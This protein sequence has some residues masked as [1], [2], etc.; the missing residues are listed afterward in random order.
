VAPSETAIASATSRGGIVSR[1]ELFER[2]AGAARVTEVSAPAGSGKTFLLRSWVRAARLTDDTAWVAVPRGGLDAPGFWVTVLDALRGTVVGSPLVRELTGAP[3]LDGWS[4]VERL[5]DDLQSLVQP[6]WVVIDDLHELR[7]DAALRQL[8]LLLMRAPEELRFVLATRHN[9]G[10]GLHRLR[11]ERGLTELRAS[12]LRFT[13]QEARAL[14]EEAGVKLSDRAVELLEARTEGWAAGLR[15]AALSLAGNSDPERFAAEFSGSERTVAQ[16]LL[17]EVLERQPEDV[18]RLLLR[19]SIL[20]RVNGELAELLT[21]APGGAALLHALE[22]ANAF[23]SSI[24]AS[25]SW[26]RYHQMF[27]DLLA[28]ELRRTAADEIPSLHRAAAEWFEKHGYH[29]EAVRHAQ[30]AKDWELAVRVLSDHWFDLVLSGQAPTAHDLVA[31]FRA[32]AAVGNPEL[33]A[34]RAAVALSRGSFEQAERQLAAARADVA[35]VPEARRGHFQ[36]M[37]GIHRL[38]IAR[39]RADLPAVA[40]EADR[41]L[42]PMQCADLEHPDISDRRHALALISLGIAEVWTAGLDDAERHLDEGIAQARRI[43]Q[44]YLEFTGLAHLAIVLSF[45]TFSL[46]AERSTEAIEMAQRHGWSEEPITGVAYTMLA[47][48]MVAHARLEEADRWLARAQATLRPEAHPAAGLILHHARGNLHLARGRNADALADYQAAG[49]LGRQLAI[50]HTRVRGQLLYALVRL[51]ETKPAEL[52]IGAMDAQ[53]Q[54]SGPV[55]TALATLRLAQNDPEAATSVLAPILDDPVEATRSTFVLAQACL[56]EAR[57][58][59]A[60]GDAGAR[61]RAL[62]RALD[63]A[64]P[65]GLLLPFLFHPVPDLLERH[66]R[67][68]TTHGSLILEIL[69]L[70]AGTRRAPALDQPEHLAEPLSESEL[71][72]LRYLPTNLSN[73]EIASELYVSVNTVKAHVKHLYTKLDT[74]H[75]G[76]AVERARALGLLAPSSRRP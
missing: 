70:L 24:D 5:L 41:L 14:F 37:L 21:G 76:E 10:L 35:S 52:A 55:R 73:K 15:L 62:E 60:L 30:A 2:L 58:R 7:S 17:A 29:V 65:D 56:L 72:V 28:L 20:D 46:A 51:G 32:D 38:E 66:S 49:R 6:V 53:L 74:H 75:R 4:I 1:R 3:D 69:N 33:T 68:H 47:A 16:Y 71:R 50:P 22:Q 45:R 11:L 18:K 67:I 8:E 23:V 9:L 44:P 40:Q 63:L 48:A 19:T 39:Q 12:D 42:A 59:D 25:R 64:E 43:E 31:G 54:Q 61:E 27:A 13:V 26:F 36:V 34:L 57:A